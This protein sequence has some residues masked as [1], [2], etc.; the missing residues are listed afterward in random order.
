MPATDRWTRSSSSVHVARAGRIGGPLER[1][2]LIMGRL[3]SRFLQLEG[4]VGTPAPATLCR[5]FE[6]RNEGK[7]LL[8]VAE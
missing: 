8:R 6:G 5:L 1:N 2:D 3:W 4:V 7:Q